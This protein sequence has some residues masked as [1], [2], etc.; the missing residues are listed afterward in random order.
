MINE[1]I[2]FGF[3]IEFKDIC[4]VYPIKNE[5]IISIGYNNFWTLYS[6]VTTSFED[7]YDL[8]REKAK[9]EKKKLDIKNIPMP[10]DNLWNLIEESKESSSL[11]KTALELFVKSEVYFLP[12]IREIIVGP[13]EE[14]RAINSNNFFDFQNIIRSSVGQKEILPPDLKMHPKKME[15]KAK[16]RERDRIKAKQESGNFSFGN[17]LLNV[18]AMNVGINVDNILNQTY[19]LTTSLYKIGSKKEKFDIDIR[20]IIAGADP[21]KVKLK[22]WT[23]DDDDDD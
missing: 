23:I 13:L 3:P 17:L 15:M 12:N 2:L 19:C 5:D 21:K 4:F 1:R 18:C 20:S 10:W 9:K 16:A 22:Q 6:L 11:I 8:C 14:H 7:L